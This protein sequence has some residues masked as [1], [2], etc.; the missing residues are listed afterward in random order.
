MN[1]LLKQFWVILVLMAGVFGSNQV[2]ADDG[3]ADRFE[4]RKFAAS[5]GHELP[6]RLLSPATIEEGKKYPVVLFLHGAGERGDDNE[7]QLVHVVKE[8]ATDEMMARYPCFVVV[9]QCPTEQKWVEVDWKLPESKMPA[10]PSVPLAAAY[11]LI[12]NFEKNRPVDSTRIYVCGLSMGGFG[13]WDCL[14][15]WPNRWAAAIPICGGGDPAF[16]RFLASIPIWAFHGDADQAVPVERTRQMID[17]IRNYSGN[18]LYTEYEGVGHDSWTRTAENRLVWDWIF[19]QDQIKNVV[20]ANHLSWNEDLDLWNEVHRKLTRRV[21]E[22]EPSRSDLHDLP[23]EVQ[24]VYLTMSAHSIVENGGFLYLFESS[25]VALDELP[26]AF[27][28]IGIPE[29]GEIYRKANHLTFGTGVITDKPFWREKYCRWLV[30]SKRETLDELASESYHLTPRFRRKLGEYLRTNFDRFLPLFQTKPLPSNASSVEEIFEWTQTLP[31][32]VYLVSE[33]SEHS[34]FTKMNWGED[35]VC[36]ARIDHSARNI[37]DLVKIVAFEP[38][39]HRIA[40]LNLSRCEIDAETISA[41]SQL[42]KLVS[43]DMSGTHIDVTHI[44]ELNKLKSLK[45][46]NLH[47]CTFS[48]N[49][50]AELT[51]LT[52]LQ[53]LVLSATNVNDHDLQVLQALPDLES[54]HLGGTMLTDKSV[55]VLS[56][57]NGLNEINLNKTKMS[58]RAASELRESL[59]NCSVSHSHDNG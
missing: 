22:S 41:L 43:L 11:E 33:S 46:L 24:A 36:Y 47:Y 10:T 45:H 35:G 6:Y 14:Q 55:S 26:D 30:A 51:E 5:S 38:I 8:L 13:T 23:V 42:P 20:K 4:A 21:F 32:N 12:E 58:D 52:G 19:S 3:L 53:R 15:R 18:C 48:S 31:V 9:P 25:M 50:I 34:L 54:I 7:R 27:E 59:P 56:E 49:C 17:A 40:H 57:C 2:I 28:R 16:A 37:D 1:F 44:H 39:G 29:L